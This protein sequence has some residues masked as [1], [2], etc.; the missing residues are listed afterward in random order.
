MKGNQKVVAVDMFNGPMGA[1]GFRTGRWVATTERGKRFTF[2][3]SIPHTEGLDEKR[4]IR[5][6]QIALDNRRGIEWI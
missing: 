2:F 5:S 4:M 1:Y 3:A 6:A